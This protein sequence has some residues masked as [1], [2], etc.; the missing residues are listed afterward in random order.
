MTELQRVASVPLDAARVRRVDGDIALVRVRVRR[1]PDG[2]RVE[3]VVEVV[4]VL[5]WCRTPDG[6]IDW[7]ASQS[8]LRTVYGDLITQSAV[9]P[10]P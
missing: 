8:A 10:Q 4:A 2:S 3:D 1:L 6:G 5:D 9:E 7:T